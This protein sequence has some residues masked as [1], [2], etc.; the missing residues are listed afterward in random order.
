MLLSLLLSFGCSKSK[1]SALPEDHNSKALELSDDLFDHS[2]EV[3]FYV[4]NPNAENIKRCALVNDADKS[5]KVSESPLIGMEHEEIT[6]DLILSRTMASKRSYFETF[7]KV[8]NSMPKETLVIFGAINSI[9]IS[10]RINPSFYTSYTGGIYLS[11]MH[12]W[13]TAKEKED[14]TIKKDYRADYGLTLAY[15]TYDRYYKDGQSL[16]KQSGSD[17]R[18][19]EDLTPDLARVLFHELTHAN[20]YYPKSFYSSAEL[21]SSKNFIDIV[22]DRLVVNEK[23]LSMTIPTKPQSKILKNAGQILYRG[24]DPTEDDLTN[25]TAAIVL[26]EFKNDPVANM[27]AYSSTREDAAMLAEVA[28]ILHYYNYASYNTFI[29]Y[30]GP[31]FKVPDEY[32]YEIAGGLKNKIADHKVKLRAQYVLDSVVGV[33][34][35]QKIIET[36]DKTQMIEIPENTSLYEIRNF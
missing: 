30:P 24:Q 3:Q 7:R 21:D 11:S 17:A 26:T 13:T 19:V 15:E 22:I 10:E 23:I 29:K 4:E 31:N 27:Y 1:K 18:T 20:D 12:F 35:S 2:E 8:L 9:I 36:L 33:E 6:V 14:S 32:V 25:V 16:Y 5:C 28:M 34:T